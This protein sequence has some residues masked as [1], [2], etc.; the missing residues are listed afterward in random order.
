[1]IRN[2]QILYFLLAASVLSPTAKGSVIC[3]R[4]EAMQ[5][6]GTADPNCTFFV[7]HEQFSSMITDSKDGSMLPPIKL[8]ATN[9]QSI[10]H[11]GPVLYQDN[12]YFTSNRLSKDGNEP[13]NLDQ[14]VNIYS[15]NLQSANISVIQPTPLSIPMANGMTLSS[16]GDSILVLSQGYNDTGS[17]IYELDPETGTAFVVLQN[18]TDGTNF[19]SMN[20]IDISR[21]GIIFFTDPQYGFDQGFRFGSPQRGNGI[22]RYD[23]SSGVVTEVFTLREFRRPNGLALYDT[24]SAED[25]T[26][27][28]ILFVT[29]TGYDTSNDVP[30]GE[31]NGVYMLRDTVNGGCFES[32]ASPNVSYP[33]VLVEA[34]GVG[35]QDGI[36]IHKESKTLLYCDGAGAWVWSVDSSETTAI[37]M[38]SIPS[39]GGG[40]TQLITRQESGVHTLYLLAETELFAVDLNFL[41]HGSTATTT[42]TDN[43]VSSET[44]PPP[45]TDT[46][47][48]NSS[49][50]SL[51]PLLGFSIVALWMVV[52]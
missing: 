12:L 23:S 38:I 16:A 39:E 20:D 35:I 48:I 18:F 22:Y 4:R 21:D 24:R 43:S 50:A 25:G 32:S 6:S 26:G 42:E 30:A 51:K 2:Y 52:Y 29:E 44:P 28:C 11:E 37:G 46:E 34:A 9:N 8:L 7:F 17:K 40:C 41:G 27:G 19:N 10:F 13:S 36:M 15:Y 49:A 31:G 3:D 45:D 14:Y 5:A 47:E 1:M 33:V